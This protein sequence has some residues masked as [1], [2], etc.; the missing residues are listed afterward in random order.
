MLSTIRIVCTS[1][2][3][4]CPCMGILHHGLLDVAEIVAAPIVGFLELDANNFGNHQDVFYDNTNTPF[5]VSPSSSFCSVLTD[6]LR[7]SVPASFEMAFSDL[8]SLELQ[9]LYHHSHLSLLSAHYCHSHLYLS[10]VQLLTSPFEL[11]WLLLPH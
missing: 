1:L 5:H 2:Y 6:L 10:P 3:H 11:T 9:E 8:A 7:S 4:S